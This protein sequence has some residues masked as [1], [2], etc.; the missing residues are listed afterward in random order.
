[1]VICSLSWSISG[2]SLASQL[3]VAYICILSSA[4]S[5]FVQR[6][7]ALVQTS[8]QAVQIVRGS[9]DSFHTLNVKQFLVVYA[10]EYVFVLS[11]VR[12]SCI[13]SV[14]LVWTVRSDKNW[15]D[16]FSTKLC[17][18]L[19]VKSHSFCWLQRVRESAA[20]TRKS[21]AQSY[22]AS[23]AYRV[24]ILI[25]TGHIYAVRHSSVKFLLY[26]IIRK[27]SAWCIGC[28]LKFECTSV[29]HHSPL[30]AV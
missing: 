25:N 29:W 1:M 16:C 28:V 27:L 14:I 21:N 13:S 5:L 10:A 12:L 11:V 15:D 17:C 8:L 26:N 9:I 6:K 22:D 4:H 30:N 18:T 23:A 24:N 19:S 20:L 3:N 2:V 7:Q